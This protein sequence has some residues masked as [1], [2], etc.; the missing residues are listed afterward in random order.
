MLLEPQLIVLTTLLRYLVI[1]EKLVSAVGLWLTVLPEDT[2]RICKTI[3][4]TNDK[5]IQIFCI[6]LIMRCGVMA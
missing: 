1:R 5:R 4:R 3:V 2:A 6:W